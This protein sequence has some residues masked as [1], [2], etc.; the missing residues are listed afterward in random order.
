MR[1]EQRKRKSNCSPWSPSL[2]AAVMRQ[3]CQK[4]LSYPVSDGLWAALASGSLILVTGLFGVAFGQ[5]WLFASLGPTAFQVTEYPELRASRVYHVFAGHFLAVG[6]G[7]A[8]VAILGAWD[9]PVVMATHHLAIIRVWSCVLA[10][11][12]TSAAMTLVRASHPPAAATC[13]LIALG[14]L[15]STRGAIAIVVGVIIVGVLGELLRILRLR[16][17]RES[18]AGAGTSS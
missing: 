16:A 18:R 8:A 3:V 11:S 12:L 2:V 10:V 4:L 9:A 15:A 7:F 6:I 14:S 5:P 17:K 1:L 13:L